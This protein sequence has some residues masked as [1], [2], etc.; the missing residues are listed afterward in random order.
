M[1]GEGKIDPVLGGRHL[2]DVLGLISRGRV[3]AIGSLIRAL[4]ISSVAVEESLSRLSGSKGLVQVRKKTRDVSS[5][6]GRRLSHGRGHR[7]RLGRGRRIT[8]G[9]TSVVRSNRAVCLKPKA[10]GR[11]VTGCI[12]SISSLEVIAGDLPMF[13]K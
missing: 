6:K 2:V 11:L 12:S 3:I 8:G 4:G 1:N 7:L 13:R 10:A 5:N 9:T